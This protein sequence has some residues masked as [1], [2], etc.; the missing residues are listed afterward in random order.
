MI[1]TFHKSLSFR[2]GLP[3]ALL[4]LFLL[5]FLATYYTQRQKSFFETRR[6]YEV[7]KVSTTLVNSIKKSI[8]SSNFE[9]VKTAIDLAKNSFE[10]ELLALEIDSTLIKNPA[11]SALNIFDLDDKLYI[12]KQKTFSTD[13]GTCKIHF[14]TSKKF[15]ETTIS[16]VNQP[17]YYLI[18]FILFTS[19]FL[20]YIVSVRL[21]KPFQELAD[22]SNGIE[23]QDYSFEL[24]TR[25]KT[26]EIFTIYKSLKSLA[27]TLKNREADKNKM[28]QLL[29]EQVKIKTKEIAQL[30]IVAQHTTNSVLITDK[31][32]NIIWANEAHLNQ[33]GYTFSEIKGKNPR[34]FQYEKTSAETKRYIR[35]KLAKRE[36]VI[37]EIQNV[38]KQGNEYWL[39]LNI[40]P[41]FNEGEHNGFIA[42]QT[43]IT[44]IKDNEEQIKAKNFELEKINYELDNF[45]YSI[46]HDLRT[47]L[48]SLK[49]IVELLFLKEKLSEEGDK[50]L[51]LAKKSISRL[52]ETI[53]EILE[54]SKNARQDIVPTEFNVETLINELIEDVNY[55]APNLSF[56][57]N[58][59]DN[60]I[61]TCDKNRMKIVL[62]NL[63]SN[64][65]KYSR[66][67]TNAYVKIDVINHIKDY[68]EI[69]VTDNGEGIKPEY[70]D[71]IFEM[72]FRGTRNSEGTGLGL[73]ICSQVIKKMKGE[74]SMES[75]YGKG[76]TF[77]VRVEKNVD[78]LV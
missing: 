36:V 49:S 12:H 46:S 37:T 78:I 53:Q 65:V 25:Y 75:E 5:T 68:M 69:V 74:I 8:E 42:V 10:F 64:S 21:S 32:F 23:K 35:T 58:V 51:Q 47:P 17:V 59:T 76:T 24:N 11:E 62:K 55:A 19:L 54:Y 40:V 1:S 28:L 27:I 2:I 34:M 39:S 77:I 70:K 48:V 67:I 3:F 61:I 6:N 15:I 66:P 63:I 44:S 18:G 38:S 33:T 13:I 20:T 45:V 7:E 30:S 50:C 14:I 29:D 71:K 73:Y 57:V 41:F 43:D 4:N 72:F 22:I 60:P 16:Q 26:Q 9:N 31:N 52:D 56:S